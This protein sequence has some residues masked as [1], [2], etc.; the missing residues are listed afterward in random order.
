MNDKADASIDLANANSF[1]F[2]SQDKIR[3]ADLDL[4]GHI[5]NISFAVYCETGRVDFRET[6][7]ERPKPGAKT[8]FVVLKVT[9]TYMRQGYYPGKVDIGTRVLKLGNSS[10]TIGQGLFCDGECIG[11][12]ET[13]WV[14]TDTAQGKSM[15]MPDKMRDLLTP[16]MRGCEA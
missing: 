10:C 4:N 8:D 11:T 1:P 15:P 14:Y 5:N 12:G 7:T 13:V 9:V 6:L 3:F 2:W 16:Y